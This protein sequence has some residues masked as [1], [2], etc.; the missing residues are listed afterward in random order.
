MRQGMR[1]PTPA[2]A[3]SVL[4]LFV[5]LGG[6]VYAAKKAKIDGKAVKAKSLPGNRIKLRSIPANRLSRGCSRRPASN[7]RGR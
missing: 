6:T 4:A 1:L 5:A 3:V 7:R 2:L